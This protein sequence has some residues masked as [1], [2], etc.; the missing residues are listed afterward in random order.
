V[1][2]QFS[3]DVPAEARIL[4]LGCGDGALWKK[5][6]DRTPAAWRIVLCDLSEG[7]L[8]ATRELGF[9]RVRTDAAKLP[10]AERSFDAVIANHMLYHVGDRP[11]ALAGIARVLKPG[12]RLYAA[13]NSQTHLSAINDLFQQFLGQRSPISGPMPFTLENGEPQLRTHF[14][15]VE[16]RRVGGELRV[17][18]PDAV[19]RYV[20]SANESQELIVG[21]RFEELNRLVREKIAAEGAFVCRTATGMFVATVMA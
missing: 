14:A 21:G 17:T 2:D 20:M 13:T 12:G 7:M 4:E 18:D 5:N 11:A 15:K 8:N 9:A 6:S 16:I 10:F 1:F 3:G 19:V